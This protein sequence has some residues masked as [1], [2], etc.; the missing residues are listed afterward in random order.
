MIH[1][2]DCLEVMKTLPDASVDMVLADMPYGTTRCK[3][4]SVIP[5]PPLWE[6]YKRVTRPNAAIVLTA[7]QPFTAALVMSAPKQFRHEWVWEKAQASG[8]L[9]A[10]RRPMAAHES[11][12]VFSFG[13]PKY[14]PQKTSGHVR[15]VATAHHRRGCVE[16]EVYGKHGLHT[17][18][19]TDRFP[20]SV[21]KF[22]T[23]K[24]RSALHPTQKPVALMEYLIRTYC[25]EGG[26]VLDNSMGS[27][28]TGI[29][30]MNTGRE[31]IGI[32]NVPAIFETARI[33]LE[34]AAQ[35]RKSA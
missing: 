16:T 30:C 34:Q 6:Q 24:Q 32:E 1:F 10:N 19:S 4:D 8:H 28:T 20:R 11:V 13:T 22:P 26:V 12:L 27:G 7:A 14:Q 17:Y 25:P 21:M 33:R 5:L 35:D 18:D 31:F 3:W 15:K 29:A 9:N 2:G 23:D